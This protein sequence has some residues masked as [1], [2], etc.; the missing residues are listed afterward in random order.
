MR[1][2]D[3]FIESLVAEL[4]ASR[5]ELAGGFEDV[6]VA[7]CVDACDCFAPPT[8]GTAPVACMTGI[9][10]DDTACVLDCSE[11]QQCPDGM[12]CGGNICVWALDE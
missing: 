2:D 5:E 10:A 7:G 1:D 4:N 11:G 12:V 8:T 6:R 9:V 3:R